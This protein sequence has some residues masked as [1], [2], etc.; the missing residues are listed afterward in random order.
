MLIDKPHE[1]VD[2]QYFTLNHETK[3]IIGQ[4]LELIYLNKVRIFS[5]CLYR[6]IS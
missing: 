5:T 6:R 2:V 3:N 4:L 1:G